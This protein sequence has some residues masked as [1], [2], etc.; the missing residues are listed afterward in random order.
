MIQGRRSGG[1]IV[2]GISLMER[3]FGR[4]I[5]NAINWNRTALIYQYRQKDRREISSEKSLVKGQREGKYRVK[6]R[7]GISLER[8]GA[9]R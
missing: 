8:L 4:D 3:G 7:G 9:D 6:G 2:M 5:P 1:N